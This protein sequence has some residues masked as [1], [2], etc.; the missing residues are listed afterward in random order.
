[1]KYYEYKKCELNSWNQSDQKSFLSF[2]SINP[3]ETTSSVAS[4]EIDDAVH[5][6]QMSTVT[7]L[8]IVT[9][10]PTDCDYEIDVCSKEGE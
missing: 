6:N 2:P 3:S 8:P 1:M 5:G 7:T 4:V 9:T 10:I